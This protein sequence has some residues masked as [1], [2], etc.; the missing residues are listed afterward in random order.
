MANAYTIAPVPFHQFSDSNGNPASGYRLFSYSAGT[1]TKLNTYADSAGGTAQ[2]NPITL[3][4]AGRPAS[5]IFLGPYSYKFVLAP[6]GTDD[7]PAS[8]EWTADSVSATPP[9]NVDLD[10][11]GTAGETLL[12]NDCVYLSDGS[13]GRT[14]GRWYKT[15]QDFPAFSTL[16]RVIG[17]VTVGGAAAASITV[18][19]GGRLTGLTG[20]T[21]GSVYYVSATAGAITL[22]APANPRRV[23]MAD[24]TTSIIIAAELPEAFKGYIPI[25]LSVFREVAANVTQNAAANGG[26]LASDTTPVYER[27]NGA[28]DKALR[29][30]WAAANVDEITCSFSYP[31]DLDDTNAVE[32]HILAASGGTTNSP[33]IAVGYFEGVGDTNAGGN[34]AAVT[35][36]TVAEYSVT[37]AA[38]DVGTHPNVASVSLTPAAHGTDALRVYALWIEYTRLL[39]SS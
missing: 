23:A 29:I 1:T 31:P 8:A 13:S 14:S 20:L 22:T 36:T 30:S 12:V 15:D 33:V 37:I 11:A 6:P 34:T 18:R 19:R 4:A 27:V 16:A 32:V 17:F 10:V 28:T 24:S 35:G 3:D 2:S 26:L 25:D 21:A 39:K 9:F 5:P 7:P 38:S